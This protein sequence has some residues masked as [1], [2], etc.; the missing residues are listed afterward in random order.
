MEHIGYQYTQDNW[1][2][3]LGYNKADST[4]VETRNPAINMFNLLGFP[5]TQEKHYTLGGTYEVSKQFS[6][7]LA[8]VYADNSTKTF[9]TSQLQMGMDSITTDHSESS[10]SFQLNYTF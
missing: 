1:A 9:D 3:R 2:L 4:V 8:Y 10:I 5:A 7:D 6:V